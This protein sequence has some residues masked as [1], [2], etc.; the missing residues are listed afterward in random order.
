[1]SASVLLTA[2]RVAATAAAAAAIVGAVAL[3]ASADDHD[4][5]HGRS[6]RPQV[7]I[8]A[9]Q[10]SPL[11]RHNPSNRF[12]NQE[13]V[14]V[15]N[16]GRRAVDLDGWTLS[17]KDGN[18]YTFHHYRLDGRSSVRVHTGA[19]RDSATDLYQDRRRHVWDTR[20]T[21]TLRNDHGG[22]VADASWG[23]DRDRRDGDRW[24]GDRDQRGDR[25]GGDRGMRHHGEYRH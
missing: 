16:G 22:F 18:A 13:W 11:E 6:Y 25:W 5:D 23:G 7:A 3:P 12:L 2:R 8:G 17:D 24:G 4:R 14:E 20:D 19:G 1:M 15:T 21:A 10:T 9:V